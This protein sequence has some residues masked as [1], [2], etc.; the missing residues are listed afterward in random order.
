M[1]ARKTIDL[2]KY[3]SFESTGYEGSERCIV[4]KGLQ[5][6]WQ[7]VESFLFQSKCTFQEVPDYR[8]IYVFYQPW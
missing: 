8:R 5:I 7:K 2:D 4:C 1:R 3:V 6:D